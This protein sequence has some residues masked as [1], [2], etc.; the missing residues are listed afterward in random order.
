M[1]KKEIFKFLFF[2]LIIKLILV[3]FNLLK[4]YDK[5]PKIDYIP[6]QVNKEYDYLI[7]GASPAALIFVERK[8][9][10]EPNSTFCI[11][12]EGGKI[13]DYL[14]F[15]LTKDNSFNALIF[16]FLG[17]FNTNNISFFELE[18][19][20]D[21]GYK[22]G[23]LKGSGLGGG[24]NLNASVYFKPSIDDCIR[25]L[26]LNNDEAEKYLVEMNELEKEYNYRT[27]PFNDIELAIKEYMEIKGYEFIKTNQI[28]EKYKKD[29]KYMSSSMSGI[30]NDGVKNSPFDML[31]NNKHF[32]ISRLQIILHCRIDKVIFNDKKAKGFKCFDK[33]KNNIDIYGKKI[34]LST[35]TISSPCI[36]QRSGIGSK[37]IIETLNI[38]KIHENDQVGEN[39]KDRPGIRL[40]YNLSNKSKY[41][42][43]SIFRSSF[44]N[45][46]IYNNNIEIC[47]E[48]AWDSIWLHRLFLT[49]SI[50]EGFKIFFKGLSKTKFKNMKYYLKT[51]NHFE[52]IIKPLY[53]DFV[54]K[55]YIKS[56][57]P[58]S[59]P[60]V[61]FTPDIKSNK[62][63]YDSIKESIDNIEQII[64]NIDFF[65]N[66]IPC[67]DKN[68][69]IE[70]IND[71]ILPDWHFIGT[72][73]IGKVVKKEDFSV[74]GVEN[75]YILDCSICKD[76]S[77]K[78]T[79]GM[80][81][82]IGLIGS[83]IINF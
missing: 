42:T 73:S 24:A 31:V 15:N 4:V 62:L 56:T 6:Y 83:K 7:A 74:I 55:V 28:T 69:L 41:D 71:E 38:N 23:V 33:Q 29:S 20:A 5:N 79:Q 48:W 35:G 39:F 67:F 66:A 47:P 81:H 57:D 21:T 40:G 8:M 22:N 78:N 51:C 63:L 37:N 14:K 16:G 36:L 18:D 10:L 60:I 2:Y 26:N 19:K 13:P 68:K 49:G 43:P 46:Y 3:I 52:F 30:R 9:L 11:I 27:Y 1:I 75:L 45:L 72:C 65:K 53:S 70:N 77:E 12:E 44:S 61:E 17:F 54:G 76:I 25:M 58:N 32:D 50:F 34:I 59:P 64:N 82:L 80:A